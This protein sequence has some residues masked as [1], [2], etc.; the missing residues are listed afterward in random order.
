MFRKI[1]TDIFQIL[2]LLALMAGIFILL[3][4]AIVPSEYFRESESVGVYLEGTYKA[5]MALGFLLLSA[6]IQ[7]MLHS[8]AQKENPDL[9]S[10]SHDVSQLRRMVALVT[11]MMRKRDQQ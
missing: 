5:L 4:A 7:L 3:L 6:V 1:A 2:A 10:L 11:D 8:V 9:K